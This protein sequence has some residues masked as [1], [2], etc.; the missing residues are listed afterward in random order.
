MKQLVWTAVAVLF[1]S[2]AVYA[3]LRFL[4]LEAMLILFLVASA[5]IFGWITKWL[6]TSKRLTVSH[7]LVLWIVWTGTVLSGTSYY[8]AY[9]GMTANLETL[10]RYIMVEVVAGAVG[11]FIKSGVENTAE[12]LK[13]HNDTSLSDDDKKDLF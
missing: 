6:A 3:I 1:V 13:P 9:R 12:R 2:L 11:Y 10:S 8:L 7:L 5:A 4:G